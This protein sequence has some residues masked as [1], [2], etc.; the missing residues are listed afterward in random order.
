MSLPQFCCPIPVQALSYLPRMTFSNA[1]R[2]VDI[3]SEKLTN[4]KSST[5]LGGLLTILIPIA[6]LVYSIISVHQFV[7]RPIVRE[8]TI[9]DIQ[10]LGI[11]PQIP[12]Q[13]L[14]QEGCLVL[15]YDIGSTQSVEN[16]ENAVSTYLESLPRCNGLLY[17]NV[18]FGTNA[19]I[20]I[21]ATGFTVIRGLSQSYKDLIQARVLSTNGN[22]SAIIGDYC[23]C[24]VI[25]VG[26]AF[27]KISKDTIVAC[28]VAQDN[29]IPR[30]RFGNIMTNISQ[31]PLDEDSRSTGVVSQIFSISVTKDLSGT[32]SATS[33][34]FQPSSLVRPERNGNM[35]PNTIAS[36]IVCGMEG[37]IPFN[38]TETTSN[39][40]GSSAYV[41]YTPQ[42][43]FILLTVEERP[44]SWISLIGQIGG[45][46]GV[47]HTL[48]FAIVWIYMKV[49]RKKNLSDNLDE[50]GQVIDD[51]QIQLL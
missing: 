11:V 8:T 7:N 35:A 41:L 15:F 26:N 36:A 25:L 42:T 14:S 32:Y 18:P 51:K 45:S 46:I 13:C 28:S 39:Y 6:V 31:T 37:R 17:I 9:H 43:T 44:G 21:C 1:V 48:F 3:F 24:D 34:N 30:F 29:F 19:S 50:Y 40:M 23:Y 22:T 5:V 12:F 47:I 10:T 2:R 49:T 38:V 33:G 4:K 16:S 20:P 27:I